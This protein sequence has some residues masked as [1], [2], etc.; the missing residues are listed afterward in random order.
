MRGE[1]GLRGRVTH[2][3]DEPRLLEQVV[4]DERGRDPRVVVEVD[5]DQL[6]EARRVVV[7]HRLRVAERLEDRVGQQH[8]RRR[9]ARGEL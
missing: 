1:V 2:L 7:A 8:L 9:G 6:A 3:G 5:V 4:V